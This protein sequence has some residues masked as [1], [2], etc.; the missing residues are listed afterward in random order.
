[1][2]INNLLLTHRHS[3]G[4]KT[5]VCGRSW[6]HATFI[7]LIAFGLDTETNIIQ[8]M[9]W[10]LGEKWVSDDYSAAVIISSAALHRGQEFVVFFV[11]AWNHCYK[12]AGGQGGKWLGVIDFTEFLR[13]LA[14]YM[15][16]QKFRQHTRPL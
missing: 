11:I 10:F 16:S 15:R 14:F 9:Q 13:N 1:M 3:S 7:N 2:I 5:V 8:V 6:K 4:G 12:T